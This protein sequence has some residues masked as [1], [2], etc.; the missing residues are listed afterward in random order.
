MGPLVVLIDRTSASQLPKFLLEPLQIISVVWLSGPSPTEK[1]QFRRFYYP[2]LWTNQVYF[3]TVFFVLM[4]E[5][6]NNL[7]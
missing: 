2:T 7:G 4:G 6:P 1:V 5:A 3:R